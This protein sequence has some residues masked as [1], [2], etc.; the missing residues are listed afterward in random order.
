MMSTGGE[1]LHTGKIRSEVELN[2]NYFRV[3][4]FCPVHVTEGLT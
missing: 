2:E 4:E 1:L 3:R